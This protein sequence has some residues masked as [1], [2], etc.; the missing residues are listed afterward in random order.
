LK[1]GDSELKN[2]SVWSK[3]QLIGDLDK[4]QNKN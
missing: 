4:H 3:Q 2:W 1:A